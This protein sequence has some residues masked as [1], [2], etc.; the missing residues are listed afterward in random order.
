MGVPVTL[1]P[2]AVAHLPPS[3][4]R[5]P[6][7]CSL[8]LVV[9]SFQRLPQ[10]ESRRAS[11]APGSPRERG[12]SVIR[13]A[14]PSAGCSLCCRVAF[15]AACGPVYSPVEGLSVVSRF[16]HGNGAV[17]ASV[18]KPFV[19]CLHPRWVSASGWSIG[20]QGS[21]CFNCRSCQTLPFNPGT[22]DVGQHASR[23]CRAAVF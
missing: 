16:F 11:S 9:C 22:T 1:S 13:L 4:L 12:P 10:K 21:V 23:R 17:R 19:T 5:Q 20:S 2:R 6:L 7:F 14:R 15:R 3:W 18:P 8:L